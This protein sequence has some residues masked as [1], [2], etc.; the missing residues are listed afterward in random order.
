[1]RN[2]NPDVFELEEKYQA[3]N[4]EWYKQYLEED[5]EIAG[6]NPQEAYPVMSAKDADDGREYIPWD[7]TP[8]MPSRK[9]FYDDYSCYFNEYRKI[10]QG[11]RRDYA[12]AFTNGNKERTYYAVMPGDVSPY[13]G[14]VV[15][16]EDIAWLHRAR[17]R[18]VYRNNKEKHQESDDYDLLEAVEEEKAKMEKNLP[19]RYEELRAKLESYRLVINTGAI[20]D[21][22]G[23]DCTDHMM[24]FMGAPSM[25]AQLGLCDNP[26]ADAFE[27]AEAQMTRDERRVFTL[28]YRKGLP[29]TTVAKMLGI[30]ESTVRYRLAKA[31]KKVKEHPVI[32][33]TQQIYRYQYERTETWKAEKKAKK[34]RYEANKAKRA[35]E[36]KAAK[37][38]TDVTG[39]T[40]A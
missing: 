1:M 23:N 39:V 6:G 33:R 35:A 25:E 8:V 28:V 19:N 5:A 17:D 29:R 34:K 38:N 21:E 26:L 11:R 16:E 14:S 3:K 2:Y 13:D 27:E 10:P 30:A 40:D 31:E 12:F 20:V 4:P 7:N 9:G 18:E 15:S 36:R 24:A 32:A 22:F 37:K